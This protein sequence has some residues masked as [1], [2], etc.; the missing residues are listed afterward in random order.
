MQTLSYP[1]FH[2]ILLT[3][4]QSCSCILNVI[5]QIQN[6]RWNS[7]RN[8]FL[9][10]VLHCLSSTHTHMNQMGGPIHSSDFSAVP[11][12]NWNCNLRG[13]LHSF[14]KVPQNIFQALFAL[15]FLAQSGMQIFLSIPSTY[16]SKN[17]FRKVS[18]DDQ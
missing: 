6:S 7:K 8:S 15:R 18:V 14:R 4:Y 12:Q 1:L 9:F 17:K 11:L 5:S 2:L 10:L 13:I 3:Y 16:D